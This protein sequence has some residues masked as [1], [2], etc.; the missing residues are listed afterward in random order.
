MQRDKT[1]ARWRCLT[2]GEEWVRKKLIY[3]TSRNGKKHDLINIDIQDFPSDSI[4]CISFCLSVHWF[5][6][7]D[8][9]WSIS[10]RIPIIDISSFLVKFLVFGSQ[11]LT[12]QTNCTLSS[13]TDRN[14]T[15]S[16][17]KYKFNN[18]KYTWTIFKTIISLNH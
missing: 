12:L 3:T 17:Q 4:L 2:P 7:Q 6:H 11:L 8:E 1:P 5:L 13:Q 14:T 18:F 10:R 16:Y 9:G 15:V